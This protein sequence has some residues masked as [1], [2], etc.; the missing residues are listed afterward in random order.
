V[1]EGIETEAQAAAVRDLQ[2][3]KGQ[4]YLFS[5]PLVSG[6]LV[7]WLRA[8]MP[9]AGAG[10]AAGGITSGVSAPVLSLA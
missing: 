9:L 8:S 7:D 3:A 5:R 10:G 6:A 4:G 2:C 1:A